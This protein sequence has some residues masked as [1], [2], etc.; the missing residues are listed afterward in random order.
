MREQGR[1]GGQHVGCGGR[2]LGRLL[3]A[4]LSEQ[5]LFELNRLVSKGLELIRY[6]D[7]LPVLNKFQ[8][9]YGRERFEERNNFLHRNFFIFK[10]SFELKF[11]E[12]RS[13]FLN[14]TI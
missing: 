3:W 13:I 1:G 7:G 5:C 10:M 12:S 2:L 4:R 9:K 8:I 6:K 11:G 14:L